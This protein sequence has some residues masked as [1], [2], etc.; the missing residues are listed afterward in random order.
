[1]GAR[2]SLK[3][4]LHDYWAVLAAPVLLLGP[5]LVRGQV[6]FWGTPALQF[7][8]WWVYAWNSLRQGSLP[9]WNPLNGMGAPLLANYQFAF[10][11]PPNWVLLGL[12]AL[13]GEANAAPA[14]AW[15]F[16][17]LSILH[18]AWAGLGMALLLRRL[19]FPWLA[20]VVG[21]LAFGL[22]GYIVARLGFFSMVWVAA[23]LPWVIYFA[24]RLAPMNSQDDH[25]VQ[26]KFIL[27]PGL[28][29]CIAMQLLAG[30]AQLSWYTLL[31][32]AAW[33]GTGAVLRGGLRRLLWAAVSLAVSAILAAGLAAVQLAPTF[34]YLQQSHRADAVA[35]EDAMTYSF[36]PWRVLTM[37]SPDFFGSP[38][39]GNYWG[40]ASYWEDHLYAGLLPLL[41]ACATVWLVIKARFGFKKGTYPFRW[42]LLVFLWSLIAVAFLFALGKNTPVFPFLYHNIPTF[43]MFQAPVR[44]LIWVAF[45]VPLLAAIG[46]EHWRCPTGK[47]L[48]W[49]RLGTAGAFAMTV[50][51]GLAWLFMRNIQLSFIRATALTGLWAL[52]FGLLT[53]VLPYAQKRGRLR[54]WQWAAVGWTLA[55]L[56]VTGWG[57]NPGAAADFYAGK[58][59]NPDVVQA[60]AGGGRVYLRQREEYDLKFRRFLRFQDFSALEGWEGLRGA[61]I[62]NLNL[63][64]G[65]AS[66]S[67]FD[68]LVPEIY[69]RWMDEIESLGPRSQKDWLAYMNVAVME[70]I[71]VRQ[72]GGVRYDPIEGARRWHWYPCGQAVDTEEEAWAMVRSAM[73]ASLQ[74]D[75][76]VILEG[77]DSESSGQCVS[78]GNAEVQWVLEAPDRLI[79]NITADNSGWL[80]LS[81]TWYPGWQATVDGDQSPLYRADSIFRAVY[82]GAGSHQVEIKYRPSGFYFGGMFSILVLLLI[83][84]L[85]TNWGRKSL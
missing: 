46:I 6:L 74:P 70:H 20:Q 25:F 22:S 14:V 76:A 13:G 4:L 8:P 78:D 34:E 63:L 59:A 39:Q 24:D 67:N 81:D 3:T 37:F 28:I 36:W 82:V 17:F 40:Y 85:L 21:G 61:L 54:A 29:L 23:W 41:L 73:N 12:A 7:V 77:D 66:T 80:V 11:Y 38:A 58:F 30:H 65:I 71:D 52:G 27:L 53:L 19:S 45:A 83:L 50:G 56:L 72:P 42:T 69:A 60:T 68:P 47:G 44:Y 32:A 2:L 48:Y 75:R 84:P 31:L 57:L 79:F 15:G 33:V 26:K 9:L 16:T 43:S 35:Y 62:P 51:A 5:L 18:L 1:M 55:D 64:D 10:F 49:F